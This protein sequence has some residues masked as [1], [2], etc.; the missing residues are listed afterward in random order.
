MKKK[1]KHQPNHQPNH[2]LDCKGIQLKG[3]EPQI[4]KI[5]F[6]REP[7]MAPLGDLGKW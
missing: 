1:K 4:G 3:K 2:Q 6:S 5:T 7:P